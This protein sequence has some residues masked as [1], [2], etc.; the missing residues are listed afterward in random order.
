M[1][2]NFFLRFLL[3]LVDDVDHLRGLSW[4]QRNED[5]NNILDRGRSEV[6]LKQQSQLLDTL[7]VSF[8]SLTFF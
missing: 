1:D 8:F 2:F 3:D 4:D 5:E 7:Q 6:S